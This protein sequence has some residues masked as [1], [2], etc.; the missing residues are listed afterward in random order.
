[1]KTNFGMVNKVA[2]VGK[3]PLIVISLLMALFVLVGCGPKIFADPNKC[4]KKGVDAPPW[5]C[6]K[7]KVKKEIEKEYGLYVEVGSAPDNGLGENFQKTEASAN[8]R[9]AFIERMQTAIKKEYNEDKGTDMN[10]AI[11]NKVSSSIKTASAGALA[12]SEIL[13]TWQHPEDNT[14]Y[15]MVGVKK[16]RFDKVVKDISSEVFGE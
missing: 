7:L 13:E 6:D 2:G 12:D 15:L 14:M 10:E 16:E 1:M 8:S 4:V 3:L 9:A 5:V 11:L